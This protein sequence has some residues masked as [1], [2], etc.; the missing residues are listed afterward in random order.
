MRVLVEV[1]IRVHQGL[2][3]MCMMVR[4]WSRSCLVDGCLCCVCMHMQKAG[5]CCACVCCG[6]CVCVVGCKHGVTGKGERDM[7]VN[8]A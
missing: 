7:M 6:V 1:G 5:C 8:Q 2:P 3:S 4:P